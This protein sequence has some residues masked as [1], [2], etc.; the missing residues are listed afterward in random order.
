MNFEIFMMCFKLIVALII[1]L[2]LIYA[3]SKALG[4]GATKFNGY[5]HMEILERMQITKE[6]TLLIVKI[7][8]KGC[9]LAAS[10]AGIEKLY[11][12]SEEEVKNIE[13]DKE[14]IKQD[15]VFLKIFN[16]L[17]QKDSKIITKFKKK[18]PKE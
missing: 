15:D 10:H 2:I 8:E 1:T 12:L 5:R 9:V 7:Q 18:G 13:K 3:M 14:K 11:E 17:G 4:K 6:C 16:E